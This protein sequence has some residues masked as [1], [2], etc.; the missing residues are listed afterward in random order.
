LPVI[1]FCAAAANPAS[2]GATAA[3][4]GSDAISMTVW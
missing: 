4:N 1:P 3:N 2:S